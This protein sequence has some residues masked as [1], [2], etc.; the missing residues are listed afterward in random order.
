MVSETIYNPDDLLYGICEMCGE[1]SDEID[2]AT[3]W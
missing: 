1:E 2:P 3:G